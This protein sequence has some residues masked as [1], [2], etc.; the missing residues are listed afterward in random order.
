MDFLKGEWLEVWTH[1]QMRRAT[2][3][4]AWYDVNGRLASG[5]EYQVDVVAIGRLRSDIAS[6]TIER[7][8]RLARLKAFEVSLRTRQ[9]GGD[10]ARWPLVC[11]LNPQDVLAVEQDVAA[12]WG[13]PAMPA[14][15]GL[16][17]EGVAPR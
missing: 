2:S 12:A 6:C 14:A 1:H 9:P 13:S 4:P 11:L 7:E 8:L 17:H 5:R 15:F 10:L 16:A 3:W